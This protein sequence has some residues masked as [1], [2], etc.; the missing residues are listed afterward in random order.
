M[1]FLY[2]TL[3]KKMN[4]NYDIPLFI[5]TKNYKEGSKSIYNRNESGRSMKIVTCI[6]VLLIAIMII[7]IAFYHLSNTINAVNKNK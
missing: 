3:L 4:N 1:R 7:I 6:I 2:L 5:N